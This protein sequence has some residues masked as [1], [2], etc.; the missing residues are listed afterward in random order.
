MI[1]DDENLG[2]FEDIGEVDEHLA[3][4]LYNCAVAV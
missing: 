1:S 2:E 3:I 4:R